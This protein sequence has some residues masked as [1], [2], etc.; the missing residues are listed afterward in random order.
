[1]DLQITKKIMTMIID[2]NTEEETPVVDS[3]ETTEATE[4]AEGE[5]EAEE[6]KAE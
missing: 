2:P 3:P 6:A 5:A 1:V 4:P